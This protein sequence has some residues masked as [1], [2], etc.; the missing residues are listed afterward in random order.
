MGIS[1]NL[2][3]AESV[4]FL[5]EVMSLGD[6]AYW[7]LGSQT[8]NHS[9]N[10]SEHD[11]LH[12]TLLLRMLEDVSWVCQ[13]LVSTPSFLPW[14]AIRYG[15]EKKIKNPTVHYNDKWTGWFCGRNY[16]RSLIDFVPKNIWALTLTVVG[17]GTNLNC[18]H[19]RF[20]IC[21]KLIQLST[22]MHKVIEL[23]FG[24]KLKYNQWRTPLY[25]LIK[26]TVTRKNKSLSYWVKHFT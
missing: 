3:M 13:L 22:D 20:A 17:I 1:L 23:K 11:N 25:S 19:G 14:T 24:K 6:H 21:R 10:Y 18:L 2:L 8:C 26:K 12:Q 15:C 16:G 9:L 5:K 4:A 7:I